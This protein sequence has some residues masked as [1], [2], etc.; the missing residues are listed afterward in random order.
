MGVG[1]WLKYSA[2]VCAML[3]LPG[4]GFAAQPVN[5]DA[6]HLL[7]D[8]RYDAL[9]VRHHSRLMQQFADHTQFTW[10]TEG[11]E[12]QRIK[13]EVDDMGKRL[14]RL[15][16]IEGTISPSE[17]HAVERL[18]PEVRYMADNTDAAIN[19]RNAHETDFWA[20]SFMQNAKNL[21]QEAKTASRIIH[22]GEEG[23]L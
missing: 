10:D 3:L 4:A 23:E 1:N 21:N 20:T 12:L 13:A 19:Y 8:M 14:S 15:Q 7:N 2:A 11:I 16:Q 18:A 5:R 22:R 17:Q 6:N 9:Q